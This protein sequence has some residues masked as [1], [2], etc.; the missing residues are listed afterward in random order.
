MTFPPRAR[1]LTGPPPLTIDDP[2]F[3]RAVTLREA[4]LAMERFL[5]AHLARGETS[6]ID[7]VSYAGL[8]TD[9][10][11]GDPAAL[12]DFLAAVDDPESH[13]QAASRRFAAIADQFVTLIHHHEALPPDALLDRVRLILPRLYAAGLELPDLAID[14]DARDA[15][16]PSTE[17][18]RVALGR[19]IGHGRNFYAEVFDP[20]AD[21]PEPPVTGS[22]SDDLA[23]IHADLSAGLDLWRRGYEDEAVWEWRFAMAH[24]SGE[25][26]TSAIRALH[27]LPAPGEKNGADTRKIS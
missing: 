9:G 16:R 18:L 25:H 24:H 6:T 5:T 15:V 13:G 2:A 12:D 27:S 20:Y 4:Y 14:D 8:H 19:R 11:A 22:L 26:V 1:R 10:G 21:P 23:D 17:H 3:D 7:L